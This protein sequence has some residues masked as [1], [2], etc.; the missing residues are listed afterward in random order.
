MHITKM[1]LKKQDGRASTGHIWLRTWANRFD[2]N[3]PYNAGNF[4]TT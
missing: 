4:L 3:K 2:G 1:I